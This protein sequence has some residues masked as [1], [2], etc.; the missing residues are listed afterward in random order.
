[1]EL[2]KMRYKLDNKFYIS[3]CAVDSINHGG[4]YTL[5][6]NAI[7]DTTMKDDECEHMN[8]RLVLEKAYDHWTNKHE[9]EIRA[10]YLDWV[11]YMFNIFSDKKLVE[12]Y[13]ICTSYMIIVKE[14]FLKNKELNEW[15][16]GHYD[17]IIEET[18]TEIKKYFNKLKED[19]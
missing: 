5:C 14:D 12:Y 1:M 18:Q 2:Q 15:Y 3:I 17:L 10:G 11:K 13:A 19:A 9:E 7:P 16:I 6:G 8:K 4:E